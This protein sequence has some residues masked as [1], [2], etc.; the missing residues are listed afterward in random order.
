MQTWIFAAHSGRQDTASGG[1]GML[2]GKQSQRGS[3]M[4]SHA[5]MVGSSAYSR[6]FMV[7]LCANHE[8]LHTLHH[9]NLRISVFYLK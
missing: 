4:R 9:M 3:F 6:L 1:A 2:S 7:F 8:V 5:K